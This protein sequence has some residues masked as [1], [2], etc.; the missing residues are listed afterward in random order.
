MNPANRDKCF[1]AQLLATKISLLVHMKSKHDLIIIV[2][3]R[4]TNSK[5]VDCGWECKHIGNLSP[6]A[7]SQSY[8][9][10]QSSLFPNSSI[11]GHIHILGIELE[12]AFFNTVLFYMKQVLL[13][14]LNWKG[15][16][17]TNVLHNFY[18]PFSWLIVTK[19]L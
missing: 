2:A 18:Y 3:F 10:F 14:V 13:C 5:T 6:S 12:P 16:M 11:T 8:S 4:V 19:E 9:P 15:K 1:V 7:F 17:L